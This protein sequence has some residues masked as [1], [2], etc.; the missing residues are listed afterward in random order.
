M[1]TSQRPKRS[2]Y[3]GVIQI[4]SYNR[5]FYLG[6]LVAAAFATVAASYLHG[7]LRFAIA[8]AVFV[9]LVWTAISLLVSHYVYDRSALYGLSWLRL[10]PSTWANIHAGLDETTG[11]L[12]ARLPGSESFVWDIFDAQQ[13]TEPSIAQAR[14][15]SAG[16]RSEHVSWRELPAA[17]QT[18]DAVF[19][20]FV[21]HEF[22]TA[23]A[24]I[25]SWARW[26][27]C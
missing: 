18:F 16:R 20:V 5:G 9:A 17:A 19:L 6:T 3:Q 21:A 11:L 2:R 12:C 25:S 26:R 23:D 1:G 27:G 15:S 22:R 10:Q 8:V 13:M 14:Q 7:A 4:L 24:P